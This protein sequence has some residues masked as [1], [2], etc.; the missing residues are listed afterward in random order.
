MSN[1]AIFV[2]LAKSLS[3]C[4]LLCKIYLI[5]I[6]LLFIILNNLAYQNCQHVELSFCVLISE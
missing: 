6:E 5:N 2:Y 3:W 4:V 1:Y